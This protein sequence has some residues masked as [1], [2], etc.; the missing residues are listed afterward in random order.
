MAVTEADISDLGITIP[1]AK[2]INW[3][4]SYGTSLADLLRFFHAAG[5]MHGVSKIRETLRNLSRLGYTYLEG[6]KLEAVGF[7][8]CVKTGVQSK[9]SGKKLKKE[10]WHFKVR[11]DGGRGER[12][13]TVG[14]L[15]L[16]RKH[17]EYSIVFERL[18]EPGFLDEFKAIH[19]ELHEKR[20]ASRRQTN[21][22]ERVEES[23][24]LTD[25]LRSALLS[26]G[27][28]PG[29]FMRAADF[30]QYGP[31]LLAGRMKEVVYDLDPTNHGKDI[32]QML[33]KIG[34]IRIEYP[35]VA[36]ALLLMT[37]RFGRATQ[38]DV[39]LVRAWAYQFLPVSSSLMGA[40]RKDVELLR[41]KTV[42]LADGH[43]YTIDPLQDRTFRP[44]RIFKRAK[45]VEKSVLE[46]L[47]ERTTPYVTVAEAVGI[48]HHAFPG[49]IAFREAYNREQLYA[50]FGVTDPRNLSEWRTAFA[51]IEAAGKADGRWRG[52]DPD[53]E[54]LFTQQQRET[55]DLF[56]RIANTKGRGSRITRLARRLSM[57]DGPDLFRRVAIL[58][59]KL[60]L[61][62]QEQ[63]PRKQTGIMRGNYILAREYLEKT[64][65]DARRI[66]DIITRSHIAALAEHRTEYERDLLRDVG[67][68]PAHWENILTIDI[69]I[70]R[71]EACV[72]LVSARYT[73]TPKAPA[74]NRASLLERLKTFTGNYDTIDTTAEAEL[75]AIAAVQKF[76]LDTAGVKADE[77]KLKPAP[78]F[79]LGHFVDDAGKIIVGYL[80]KAQ[81]RT[82][83]GVFRLVSS[84]PIRSAL[85]GAT[86][87]A[88]ASGLKE[89][90]LAAEKDFR[91]I[92]NGGA[93]MENPYWL[94]P[95][96]VRLVDP[97]KLKAKA[98]GVSVLNVAALKYADAQSR[99][100]QPPPES[101][102][103]QLGFMTADRRYL[104]YLVHEK[105]IADASNLLGLFTPTADTDRWRVHADLVGAVNIAF[106]KL[107]ERLTEAQT[108][109]ESLAKAGYS[110][111]DLKQRVQRA[112]SQAYLRDGRAVMLELPQLLGLDRYPSRAVEGLDNPTI[113]HLKE[114]IVA[115]DGVLRAFEALPVFDFGM[116]VDETAVRLVIGSNEK[117]MW[118][119]YSTGKN[120]TMEQVAALSQKG[121]NLGQHHRY[122]FQGREW[123]KQC[124]VDE[125][126]RDALFFY[127]LNNDKGY[128]F[129][130]Q[131]L[132]GKQPS[133]QTPSPGG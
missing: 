130:L 126:C 28:D 36:R 103:N 13:G 27:V 32:T 17:A 51:K 50:Y 87:P 42:K 117:V 107:N 67:L 119:V 74:E 97:N 4:S 19:G 98:G 80:S 62:E 118:G 39:R 43:P 38:D 132:Q 23:F 58:E 99:N 54:R 115:L 16:S 12:F 5:D 47:E 6:I 102:L 33:A 37:S 113:A 90:I 56:M 94:F 45:V 88:S 78:A 8:K 49:L 84:D 2:V 10:V 66:V 63:D 82:I 112:A 106:Q 124:T 76:E 123:R 22:E 68:A 92:K 109:C 110:I 116:M 14:D 73:K 29:M 31:D 70:I 86:D 127:N 64:G 125:L 81:R 46:T 85:A 105:V 60:R 24:H 18:P 41:S 114:D 93:G 79:S 91:Y 77:G 121:A 7:D 44:V 122:H 59:R 30:L 55:I 57:S 21:L 89:K 108:K 72:G 111:D 95:Q 101:S 34:S 100:Y 26:R 65:V 96:V 52:H 71:Q 20:A 9:F 131:I 75:R 53:G 129:R 1:E 83:S 48:E 128:H 61:R 15:H 3:D 11:A 69:P 40:I 25:E 104:T 35:D 120:P 133:P